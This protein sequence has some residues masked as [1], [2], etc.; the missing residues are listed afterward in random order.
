MTPDNT[1]SVWIIDDDPS[2]RWVLERALSNAKFAVTLFET[3]SSAL[4]R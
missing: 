1:H 4:S 2:I 3:A